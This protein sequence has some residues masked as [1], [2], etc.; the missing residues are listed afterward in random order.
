V[1]Q[2]GAR[3][4]SLRINNVIH[5]ADWVP[6]RGLTIMY[7]TVE[8]R[9]TAPG[10]QANN[11]LQ[12]LSFSSS[13]MIIEQDEIVAAN[14]GGVYGWWGTTFSWSPDGTL[15]AY[16][17]P[18][19]VGLVDTGRGDFYPLA[20]IIPLQTGSNWA[21]VSGL[22]WADNH[23]ILYFTNHVPKAGLES[24]EA[25]PLFDMVALPVSG[26]PDENGVISSDLLS[27]G[28]LISLAPQAG[29]FAYPVVSPRIENQG[30]RVAY[31][32]AIFPEQSESKRY[33][34]AVMDRDGS[35]QQVIFPPAD[36]QGLDPHRLVWS[37]EAF[38][39]GNLWLA[40][41]YQGNLWLVD[42]DN[43]QVHQVTGDGL[44]SRFGID[45]K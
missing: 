3:P 18:D 42:S 2:E 30:F 41:I 8:P 26:E 31:L 36:Y 32:E 27:A 29:M 7:S 12:L 38:Q 13:G 9:A 23:S 37:P 45:W 33:R 21:W 6:G 5:Y 35:N 40:V 16:A 28:P 4:V 44:I 39:N 43:G 22:S 10:W 20:D 15:L 19:G 1:I 34:L 17:R 14:A 11:D 25:S 24:Q